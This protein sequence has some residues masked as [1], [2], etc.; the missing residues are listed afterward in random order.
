METPFDINKYKVY[1]WKN[2]MTLHFI[3]NP[4]LAI[5]EL[6]LGQRIP[7]IM[8]EDKTSENP[9]MERRYVPCPHCDELH[10]ARIWSTNSGTAFK[11]WF[12]LYCINCGEIIPCVRNVTSFLILILTYPIWG[13]FKDDLKQKWLSRQP[14]RYT[15][16]EIEVGQVEYEDY[17]WIKSGLVWGALMFVIMTPLFYFFGTEISLYSI[18]FQLSIWALGGLLFGYLMK[19]FLGKKGTK[20]ALHAD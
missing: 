12:G 4:G 19:L 5:N 8:L 17:N 7:K 18:A 16:L 6:I 1:T 15:D 10:D 9:R 14:Q 20:P 11:N 2:W 13:W 3:L